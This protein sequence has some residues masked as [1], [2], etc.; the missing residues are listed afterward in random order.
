MKNS[1]V[2]YKK[3]VT[4]YLLTGMFIITCLQASLPQQ[5]VNVSRNLNEKVT[6]FTDRSIYAVGEK[7]FFRSYI[8]G[9]KGMTSDFLSKVLYVE[10][11]KPNGEPVF[12]GKYQVNEKGGKG[13]LIIPGNLATGDY[14]IRSYTRWMQN[15]SSSMYCYSHIKIINPFNNNLE[16]YTDTVENREEI[17]T[18]GNQQ[19]RFTGKILCNTNKQIYSARDKVVVTIS[20]NDITPELLSG[21][22]MTVIR[23]NAN[24][25]IDA[26]IMELLSVAETTTSVPLNYLPEI[27]GL[28]ISGRVTRK[29]DNQPVS[30]SRVQ[31]SVSGNNPSDY[32]SYSTKPDGK[33]VFAFKPLYGSH[34]MY[35][36][37]DSPNNEQIQIHINK[38][39]A[40]DYRPINTPPF[41]LTEEEKKTAREIML[42]MQIGSYFAVPD[43][44]IAAATTVVDT[45]YPCFYGKP[46]NIIYIDKYVLLPTLSE[47]LLELVPGVREVHRKGLVS[48]MV[49]KKIDN[50]YE[51]NLSPPLILLDL[52]PVSNVDELLKVPPEK[53]DRIEVVN[54]V[55]FKGND[56]FGG[57]ISIFTR[58]GGLAGFQLPGNSFFFKFS[59]YYP[60]KAS[61]FPDYKESKGDL[62]HPDFRNC[63]YWNPD[64]EPVSD[65]NTMVNFYTSD[66]TGEFMVW[67]RG[68][69]KDGKF[70]EGKC[71]FRVEKQ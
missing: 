10:L 68:I 54:D 48:L 59:G 60:Q 6:L 41:S 1:I 33:F 65:Q 49:E 20:G 51:A 13:Y 24:D 53:I 8:S 9:K 69:T 61:I 4:R 14:Y 16:S 45:A 58:K 40:N 34:E 11:I 62:N 21:L 56:I 7:L 23:V 30:G 19:R 46:S 44:R 25:T 39:F 70:A 22:C 5:V 55:Y 50:H 27:R 28:S 38:E 26:G 3:T 47:V 71:F 63:L 17:I 42:N 67:V 12:Q 37:A 31:L 57:V 36:R 32:Q 15:F 64:I 66:A 2:R 35:V 52:V 43:E 18:A 29:S